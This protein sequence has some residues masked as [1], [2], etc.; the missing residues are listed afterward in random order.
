[1]LGLGY[2]V[3]VL[4]GPRNTKGLEGPFGVEEGTYMG[5]IQIILPGPPGIRPL[6]RKPPPRTSSSHP[7]NVRS[8]TAT[9]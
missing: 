3:Q 1:M 8:P 4:G 7:K 9:I 6:T 5:C 2:G